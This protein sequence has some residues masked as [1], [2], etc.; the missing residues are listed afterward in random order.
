[1]PP[2]IPWTVK[3]S[4]HPGSSSQEIRDEPDWKS[5]QAHEHRVGFRNRDNR[6]PGLTHEDDEAR[7]EEAF[8]EEAA[9]KH[10]MLKR[11]AENGELINFRDVVKNEVDRALEYPHKRPEGWR[12]VL[13]ETEGWVKEGQEWPANV[14]KREKEE[15]EGRKR[16]EEEGGAEGKDHDADGEAGEKDKQDSSEEH[17]WKRKEEGANKHHD[18]YATADADSN[19]K[20]S[21]EKDSNENDDP[22]TPQERALLKA[23]KHELKYRKSLAENTGK[24]KPPPIK[25][26]PS[27]AIDEADQFTPDNWI[28]RSSTLVRLTGKHPLNAESELSALFG[29]GLITPNYLHY[30]RNHGAVP[31]ILWHDHRLDVESGKLVLSMD[32]LI[33]RFEA[34]SIPVSLACDGNRRKELNLIRKSKGF[35]WGAGATGCVYWTGVLLR[36]VL[37]AAG[38]EEPEPGVRRWVNFRGSDEPSEGRYET[39]RLFF[40]GLR[41]EA[42]WI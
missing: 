38:V 6:V 41:F 23:L 24:L 39:C 10:A 25:N 18:A 28:P 2:N 33:R 3:T 8:D 16:R 34:I 22:Y 17:D 30:V 7:D 5:A 19:E 11:R 12:F 36:D 40:W 21:N 29:G 37:L 32:E 35:N 27:I 14:E 1:M 42:S 31:R 20:E 15:E 9:R 13:P 4:D 26:R